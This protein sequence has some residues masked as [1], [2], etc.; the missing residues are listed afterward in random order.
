MAKTVTVIVIAVLALAG[1]ASVSDD[2]SRSTPQ[3][4]TRKVPPADNPARGAKPAP[5]VRPGA[6]SATR[7]HPINPNGAPAELPPVRV[8]ALTTTGKRLHGVPVLAQS[9]YG[10]VTTIR[11]RLSF[12]RLLHAARV[13]AAALVVA[14]PGTQ[15][16]AGAGTSG[17]SYY[18]GT[19]VALGPRIA[20]IGPKRRALT[21]TT[22]APLRAGTYPVLYVVTGASGQHA[23]F[24]EAFSMSGR[25]GVV[26]IEPHPRGTKAD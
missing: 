25:L 17:A 12:V 21:V 13:G 1:C 22:P 24:E 9:A 14:R 18:R 5:K 16:A 6:A 11:A 7:P 15:A 20:A 8:R 23:S 26:V 3:L 4:S 2:G 19:R 10:S